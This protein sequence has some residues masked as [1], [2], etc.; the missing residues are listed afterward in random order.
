MIILIWQP[1]V[2]NV[3]LNSAELRWVYLI[4]GAQLF[5]IKGVGRSA[6][7][8]PDEDLHY[9]DVMLDCTSFV[10]DRGLVFSKQEDPGCHEKC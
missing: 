7:V 6:N 8:W 10:P 5:T 9:H 3:K 4:G 2:S 1:L